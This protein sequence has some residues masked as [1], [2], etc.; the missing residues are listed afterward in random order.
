LAYFQFGSVVGFISDNRNGTGFDPARD[1]KFNPAGVEHAN[2][3]SIPRFTTD[4]YAEGLRNISAAE[5][6]NAAAVLAGRGDPCRLIGWG[7][8]D[9]AGKNTAEV[10]AMLASADAGYRMPTGPENMA[11][12]DGNADR[13]PEALEEGVPSVVQGEGNYEATGVAAASPDNPMTAR[14]LEGG[15]PDVI[16]PGVGYRNING[17]YTP[18]QTGPGF[19]WLWSSTPTSWDEYAAFNIGFIS[20]R[21]WSG[22]YYDYEGGFIVRC[23]RL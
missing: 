12:V 23:V 22:N 2:Y 15:Y 19:T 5:Y 1:I 6:H 17:S 8:A 13:W 10:E 3:L 4:D 21:A 14:F 18:Q 20:T 11:F 9:F 7:G 16:V